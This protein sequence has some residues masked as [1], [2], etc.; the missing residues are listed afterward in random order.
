MIENTN[1]DRITAPIFLTMLFLAVLMF[2][3]VKQVNSHD[4]KLMQEAVDNEYL[5]CLMSDGCMK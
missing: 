3:W 1:G 4:E 2:V 5:S